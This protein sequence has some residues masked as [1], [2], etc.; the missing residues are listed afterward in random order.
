MADRSIYTSKMIK[1]IISAAEEWL[2]GDRAVSSRIIDF[3]SRTRSGRFYVLITRIND[4]NLHIQEIVTA[5]D[6]VNRVFR[7]WTFKKDAGWQV[8]SLEKDGKQVV[9]ADLAEELSELN[10]IID[11]VYIKNTKSLIF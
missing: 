10:F 11:T 3:K 4:E 9:L 1:R 8:L 6:G 7:N 2:G 5:A